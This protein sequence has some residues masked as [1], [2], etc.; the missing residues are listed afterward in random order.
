MSTDR[1]VLTTRIEEAKPSS[2][3]ARRKTTKNDTAVGVAASMIVGLEGVGE[4]HSGATVPMTAIV[5]GATGALVLALTG[6]A[7]VG[8]LLGALTA[9]AGGT[10][11]VALWDSD[12][13]PTR[14]GVSVFVLLFSALAIFGYA[15][16]FGGNQTIAG[17]ALLALAGLPHLTKLQEMGP[18]GDLAGWRG[19]AARVLPVAVGAG[20][21]AGAVWLTAS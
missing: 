2:A 7:R 16:I 6:T 21:V 17:V 18:L 1:T 5:L 14:G 20:V 19:T 4:R 8:E 11:L 3:P 9:T 15:G 10:L 13:R 12:F